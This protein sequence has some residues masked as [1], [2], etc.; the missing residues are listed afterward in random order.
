MMVFLLLGTLGEILLGFVIVKKVTSFIDS[1]MF[2]KGNKGSVYVEPG[3]TRNLNKGAQ[4]G[5]RYTD[6]K[7]LN[8]EEDEIEMQED[9]YGMGIVTA[10]QKRYESVPYDGEGIAYDEAELGREMQEYGESAYDREGQIYR[11]QVSIKSLQK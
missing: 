8:P 9:P 1:D 6:A 2:P 11:H 3:L 4:H 10:V 5:S 7:M